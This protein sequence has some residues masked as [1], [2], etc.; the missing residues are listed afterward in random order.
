MW[1]GTFQQLFTSL[2]YEIQDNE[3]PSSSVHSFTSM[4]IYLGK[5]F[6]QTCIVIFFLFHTRDTFF[7]FV[8]AEWDVWLM[9]LLS[10]DPVTVN[11][12][13]KRQKKSQTLNRQNWHIISPQSIPSWHNP[14]IFLI[15]NYVW[16]QSGKLLY[17][18]SRM[19]K[20]DWWMGAD[21]MLLS[22]K[23]PWF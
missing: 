23:I 13:L 17:F 3:V 18:N 22:L 4:K 20:I 14:R 15:D 11:Q 10:F 12:F 16:L 7:S 21:N 6:I 5:Y 8:Y 1:V 9:V 2:G 19:T